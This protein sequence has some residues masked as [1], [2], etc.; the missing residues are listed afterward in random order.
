VI[1]KPVRAS[2][3]TDAFTTAKV[4][5]PDKLKELRMTKAQAGTSGDG[6]LKYE[7]ETSNGYTSHKN[8]LVKFAPLSLGYRMRGLE[9]LRR[10]LV[11]KN[12]SR[13]LRFIIF[14]L[15]VEALPFRVITP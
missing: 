9:C 10:S 7:T 3:E 2:L 12:R 13:L 15:I 6:R 4:G 5:L 1:G 8:R 11:P 14:V